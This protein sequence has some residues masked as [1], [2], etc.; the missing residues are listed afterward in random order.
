VTRQM[1]RKALLVCG[2]LSSLVYLSLDLAALLKYPGYDFAAQTI[3]E[4]SAIGS[5]SRSV[6]VALGTAYDA[7]LIAFGAGI[8]LSAGDKRSLRVVGALLI[9]AAVFG[10]F[11]P[12]MHMRGAAVTLTDKLHI[13]WTAG[14]L[15]LTMTAMGFAGAALG[16]RFLCYTIATVVVVLLFGVLTGLQGP[17]IP[18]NLPTPWAG[19]TERI[20]IGAFLLW[21]VV[22][23][24]DLWPRKAQS[25]FER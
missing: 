22:L 9:A 21:I 10:S 16:K 4:L 1:A 18:A 19:I 13:T 7:L 3:S 6:I 5:P 17:R 24:I 12:P 25:S 20:N 8:W 23:A 2:I 14:W 11:W 15:I